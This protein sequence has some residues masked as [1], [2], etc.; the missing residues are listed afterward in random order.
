MVNSTGLLRQ[1]YLRTTLFLDT[2]ETLTMQFF[3][4]YCFCGTVY[5]Y[6]YIYIYIANDEQFC[7]I[8]VTKICL[9][10]VSN[11]QVSKMI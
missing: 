10:Q 2:F 9:L 6:I 8:N 11:L 1:V 7:Y 3:S 5:I 4:K